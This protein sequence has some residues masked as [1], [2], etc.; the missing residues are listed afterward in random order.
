MV[1]KTD[2]W[3]G[4]LLLCSST[5]KAGGVQITTNMI[6]TIVDRH[7]R[8]E[9][10]ADIMNYT[11]DV[12]R[13]NL[14]LS[15][16]TS[17]VFEIKACH[18]FEYVLLSSSDVRNSSEPLYEIIFYNSYN[19]YFLITYCSHDSLN[20]RNCNMEEFNHQIELNCTMYLPFWISWA[21]GDIRVGTG[22]DVSANVLGN[23]TNTN[24]F[25]VRSIGVF[26]R[27][28]HEER[29]WKIQIEDKFA[30]YFDSCSMDNTK[31]DMVVVGEIKCSEM[32]CATSCGM[33]KTCMG[34]NFNSA[35]NR[36]ELLWFGSD[37]VTDIPHHTE[38]GW[39]FYS[40]CFN[41]KTA[42]LGCYF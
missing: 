13:Y 34:Y 32:R 12:N 39:K 20:S 36:C 18:L 27:R 29:N 25:E 21:G 2:Q 8:A 11:I 6:P 28:R 17:F 41:G 15:G 35:M 1:F 22:I 24:N 38:A 7:V 16:I 40:K 10:T 9:I 3:F 14:D 23:V 31:S 37:V 26:T 33:S 42:C 4:V 30:G 5:F 19:L